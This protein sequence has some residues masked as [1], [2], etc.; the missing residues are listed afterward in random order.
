MSNVIKLKRSTTAGDVP[1]SSDLVTGEVAQNLTDRK[2]YG[3]DGTDIV[4][5]DG[6]YIAAAAPSNPVEG[7][8]W[9]DTVND[10]LK[11]YDGTSFNEVGIQTV[12]LTNWTITETSGDLY[13]ATGGTNKMKL[14]SAGNLTV[15]GSVTAS[16][17]L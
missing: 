3:Y 1:T 8:L 14:D 7:D 12:S 16:G 17:T 9:F 11:A 2:L 4:R 15:V 6:A 13:F 10:Q 5:F